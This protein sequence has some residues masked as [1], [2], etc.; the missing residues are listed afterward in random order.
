MKTQS[1]LLFSLKHL[2]TCGIAFLIGSPA[3]FGVDH[4]LPT[5]G[6]Q[7]AK[8]L[9]ARTVSSLG[10]PAGVLLGVP[11]MLIIFLNNLL[12][13]FVGFALPFLLANYTVHFSR[14]RG[15]SWLARSLGKLLTRAELKPAA[16][17]VY[18]TLSLLAVVVSFFQGLFLI[19]VFPAYLLDALGSRAL[20]LGVV[21]VLPHAPFEFLGILLATSSALTLRDLLV[22]SIESEGIEGAQSVLGLW[23]SKRLGISLSVVVMILLAAAFLEVFV[24][25]PLLRA[26]V[27]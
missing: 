14:A 26:A 19:G 27:R 4:L 11:Q 3:G 12:P 5:L 6:S 17:E 8:F 18:V 25:A 24:S 20:Q 22:A 1:A 21:Y 13:V 23:R 15:S 9:E 2:R 7:Y 16:V 10:T